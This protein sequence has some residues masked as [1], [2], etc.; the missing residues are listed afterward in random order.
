MINDR[1]INSDGDVIM[2]DVLTLRDS[3]SGTPS[4]SAPA[5]RHRLVFFTGNV[6]E[7]C[8][9]S[10][11]YSLSNYVSSFMTDRLAGTV[12]QSVVSVRFQT[13]FWANWPDLDFFYTCMGN[14]DRSPETGS[15][16]HR[17]RSRSRIRVKVKVNRVVT[18]SVWP[19][20]SIKGSLCSIIAQLSLIAP[21]VLDAKVQLTNKY[22]VDMWQRMLTNKIR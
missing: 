10:E 2:I 5:T 4:Q 20:R 13:V 6:L 3:T 14:N 19:Q 17:S 11:M 8:A 7:P 15:Q 1:V 21:N 9:F 12:L 18:R 16:G 22:V